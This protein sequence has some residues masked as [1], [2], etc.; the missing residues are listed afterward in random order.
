MQSLLAGRLPFRVV[1]MTVVDMI[2]LAR[3]PATASCRYCLPPELTE[4]SW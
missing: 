4:A 2:L 3:P 1:V